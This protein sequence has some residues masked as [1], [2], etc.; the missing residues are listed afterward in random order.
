MLGEF[1]PAAISE[2]TNQSALKREVM[3][4]RSFGYA[5]SPI[6]DEP[7]IMQNGIP[8]PKRSRAIMYMPAVVDR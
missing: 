3:I 6:N 8:K 1:I 7:A 2:P 5:S 4:G